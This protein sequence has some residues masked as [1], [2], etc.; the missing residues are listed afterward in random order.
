MDFLKYISTPANT[1]ENTPLITTLKLTKG[2]LSGGF[3]FFPTGPAGLL[4]FRAEIGVHQIIPFNTG[5]NYRLNGCIAPFHLEIDILQPPFCVDCITW[6]DSTIY[7]HALT[8]CFFLNPIAWE[9]KF[10]LEALKEG[11]SGRD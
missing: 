8:V 9:D 11:V 10:N 1:S 5:E 7:S 2:R 3:L 4:H 6:N